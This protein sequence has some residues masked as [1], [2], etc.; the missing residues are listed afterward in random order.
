MLEN[1][2]KDRQA[3]LEAANTLPAPGG[4]AADKKGSKKETKDVKKD[5]KKA[6]KGGKG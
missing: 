4:G 6:G 3:K 2:E 1:L 5:S